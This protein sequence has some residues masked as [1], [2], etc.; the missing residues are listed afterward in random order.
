MDFKDPWILGLIPL[1]L[2]LIWF[3]KTNQRA[4]R[5]RFSSLG[6]FDKLPVTWRVRLRNVPIILR[7]IVIV[8]FKGEN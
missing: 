6:L 2:A 4:S 5:I 1:V 7:I 3:L 8:I